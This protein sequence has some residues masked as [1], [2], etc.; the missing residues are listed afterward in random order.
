MTSVSAFG[1][2]SRVGKLDEP[3]QENTILEGMGVV[4]KP[5]SNAMLSSGQRPTDEL[6]RGGGLDWGKKRD[7]TAYQLSPMNLNLYEF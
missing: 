3:P 5:L 4:S 2:G 6:L 7:D 1:K